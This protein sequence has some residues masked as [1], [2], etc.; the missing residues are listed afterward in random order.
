MRA[1]KSLSQNFLTSES[2]I[3][4]IVRA[5]R[6]QASDHVL[7]IGPGK[8][9]L[10]KIIAP[11]VKRLIAL[12]LDTELLPYLRNEF[13]TLPQVEIRESDAL[14]E[15][16][17][18]LTQNTENGKWRVLS[19]LPYHIGTPLL[20]RLIEF[21]HLFSD[22]LL[23][24]QKEVANKI[25][26]TTRADAGYLSNFVNLFADVH[27]IADVPPGA[28]SPAPK[29]DSTVLSLSFLP[30]PRYEVRNMAFFQKFIQAAFSQRRKTLWNNL[31]RA[32]LIQVKSVDEC[33]AW[34]ALNLD[35]KE[36]AE[37]VSLEILVSLANRLAPIK[38]SQS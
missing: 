33:E 34:T 18:S 9:A 36:R 24:F 30:G 32:N 7:E 27:H 26:G 3:E 5:F 2:M 17:A 20:T 22:A 4:Q 10:T 23:M 15:D 25:L 19:N 38:P 37:K 1:K 31:R 11:K 12:E 35:P 14:T 8:G 13:Q 29:V 28:F 21:R 6:P 16:W